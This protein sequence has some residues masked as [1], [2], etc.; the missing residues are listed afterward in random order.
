MVTV[1]SKTNTVSVV[2]P[3]YNEANYID[4]CLAALSRQSVK[5]LE[6]ILVDNN[7]T[8]DTVK[9]ASLYPRVKIV[10]QPIQGIAYARNAGFDAARGDIIAR[11]D[12][13]T[14]VPEQWLER[15]LPHFEQSEVVGVS[16]PPFYRDHPLPN[17]ASMLFR[18]YVTRGT[19]LISGQ[20]LLWGSNMAFRHSVWRK[21]RHQVN[22]SSRIWEDVD[23]SVRAAAHGQIVFDPALVVN[24]SARSALTGMIGLADYFIRWPRTY[25][26]FSWRMYIV[27][28]LLFVTLTPLWIPTAFVGLLP[29]VRLRVVQ[30]VH[31][32]KSGVF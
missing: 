13:D 31:A 1:P 30:W 23:L 16:G 21:V 6:I 4:G 28:H 3:A 2:I 10:R 27:S 18:Q 22:N 7:C 19:K 14:V 8:D 29:S 9:R 20:F 12:A 24:A 11:I 5:P 32:A 15:L 17:L 26:Q 25:G